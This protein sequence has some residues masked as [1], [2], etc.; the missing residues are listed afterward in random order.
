M[1]A[2]RSTIRSN[3]VGACLG[4]PRLG[5]PKIPVATK[6]GIVTRSFALCNIP[7]S[8]AFSIFKYNYPKIDKRDYSEGAE[9]NGLTAR[10]Y[11]NLSDGVMDALYEAL[12]Q[13]AEENA[14]HDVEYSVSGSY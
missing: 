11:A 2:V 8:S 5:F 6:F 7:R 1:F 14:N 3:R 4:N 9:I 13:F 12:D 10:D